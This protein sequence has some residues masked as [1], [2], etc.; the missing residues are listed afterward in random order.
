MSRKA[1]LGTLGILLVVVIAAWW[2]L[3]AP[4]GE[5]AIAFSLPESV[6]V[7][8]PF[9]AQIIITNNSSAILNRSELTVL[10][11]AGV[12]FVGSPASKTSAIK[13]LGTIGSGGVDTETFS[14]LVTEGEN[15]FKR[16][17]AHLAYSLGQSASRYENEAHEDINV[18]GSAFALDLKT[19]LK[20]L[21]SEDFE[22]AIAYKNTSR[23]EASSLR[24]R[25]IYP[26]TFRFKTSSRPADVGTAEWDLGGLH[27]GS[28]GTLTLGGTI[29]AGDNTLAEFSAE[30][31][32][33]VNGE[34]YTVSRSS[35]TITV[36]PSPL[37][38]VIALNNDPA[39]ISHLDDSLNY[40]LTY[41]NTTDT[42]L[43][44]VIIRA[45]L[46]GALYDFS[47]LSTRGTFRS[48]DSSITWN[49]ANTAEL[50]LLAPGASGAATFSLST[51]RDFPIRRPGD[52][53][54]TLKA[55]ASIE[56]PT[57][58]A[59]L[60]AQKTVGIAA[61]ETKVMGKITLETLGFFRDAAA[62]V[63]NAGVWPPKVDQAT[64]FTIHWRIKNYATEAKDITVKAFLG[65]NTQ[66]LSVVKNNT[67]FMPTYNDRTQE[68]VWHLD[69]LAPNRGVIDA[70][71]EVVFQIEAVPPSSFAGSALP[72][73]QV[74][75]LSALDTFTNSPLSAA[76]EAIT[77]ALPD[78]QTVRGEGTVRP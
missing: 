78:D 23:L 14:L 75:T 52:K 17:E 12:V 29:I 46:T 2:F 57:V 8:V 27:A 10:L 54:F 45:S 25:M 39:Y 42:A 36:S 31:I 71:P 11:P 58:P 5:A 38:L 76:D 74:S 24:L 34:T 21:N 73:I 72:L 30:L 18:G 69:L 22:I 40:T 65:G 77:T 53:N 35:A 44:D 66:F 6:S 48:L 67:Q 56:S 49:A 13:E 62:G 19:P 47:R 1:L 64:Q 3:R 70:P 20:V 50:T 63:V 28:E 15:S 43:R 60:S 26:Q 55:S 33:E 4:Q 7:G 68:V 51:F 41:N 37:T 9:D 59:N 16:L 61:I 32:A